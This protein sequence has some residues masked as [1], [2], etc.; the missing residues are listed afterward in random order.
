MKKNQL[1]SH[2][3]QT[4]ETKLIIIQADTIIKLK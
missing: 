2:R 4:K 3:N 1:H